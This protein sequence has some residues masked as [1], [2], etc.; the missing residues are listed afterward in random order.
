MDYQS[1]P[2][3]E[4]G[5]SASQPT[6]IKFQVERLRFIAYCCFWGMCLFAIIVSTVTV[7]P[8][9]G[10]CPL[11][12][13]ADPT[14]GI[15]CSALK[16]SFGFNNICAYWDYSPS[17]EATAMVYPLF[18]YSILVYIV[19]DYF[20]RK[21]DYDNGLIGEGM[22]KT[23]S[24][25]LWVKIVLVAMFR[26]IFVCAIDQNPIP[27]FGTEMPA[28]VAHT[29]GFFAM[30]FALILIAFENVAYIFYT[31]KTLMG[32]SID[33]TKHLAVAYLVL[34][35]LVTVIKISWASSLFIY[36]TPWLH[37]PWPVICDRTWMF[38]A[39]IMPVIL[40]YHY[41]LTERPMVIT[42]VNAPKE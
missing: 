39:A 35:A 18:E 3:I 11:T 8:S 25:L 23:T 22:Y 19:A 17:R 4:T 40:S 7:S 27:F 32:L 9:L 5:G 6:V 42:I 37:A 15:H 26:M 12:E 20:Q 13:G 2:M 24:I 28:V 14:Y 10:P 31:K 34:L 21:N 38:L 41:S 1:I 33:M 29:L 16:A 30:Q 36:G